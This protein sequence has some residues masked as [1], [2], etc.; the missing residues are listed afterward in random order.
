MENF[1][2][3]LSESTKAKLSS[4]QKSSL[5]SRLA[6]VDRLSLMRTASIILRFGLPADASASFA[7]M[8]EVTMP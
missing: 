5:Q 4:G 7:V 6:L 2:M 8:A 3:F 1:R